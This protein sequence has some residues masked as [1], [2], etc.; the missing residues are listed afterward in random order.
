[1]KERP[2]LVELEKG[3]ARVTLNRPERRNAFNAAMV[4]ELRQAFHTLGHNRSVR[5][6]VLAGAGGTFCAGADLG[7]MAPE[8]A[9]PVSEAQQDAERLMAMYRT[10]DECSCPVIGRVQGAAYGGGLGLIAVCDMAVAAAD[11]AF[12]FSEVR[13]GLVPAVIAP[14]V[15]EKTGQSFARRFFLSGE[16]FSAATARD[17]GLVHDV[18]EPA[19]LDGRIA[20]L[21]E[22]IG[23]M[24]PQAVRET[25]L[26]LRRLGRLTEDEARKSCVQT[27]V[28]ARC[29][30]EAHE[31]IRAFRARRAPAWDDAIGEA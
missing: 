7:W 14:F 19:A 5:V 29:S 8:R 3:V 16:S 21:T 6:I 17:A 12:A 9:V 22:Q 4:E 23:Q 20:A 1:M 25:K 11:A 24:A 31:G 2:V 26:L 18:I 27:N 28:R 10:I 15:L 30:A 13:L